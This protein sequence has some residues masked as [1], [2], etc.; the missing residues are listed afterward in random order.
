MAYSLE[1]FLDKKKSALSTKLNSLRDELA[2]K[3]AEYE[4]LSG[5]S[6]DSGGYDSDTLTRLEREISNLRTLVAKYEKTLNLVTLEAKFFKYVILLGADQYSIEDRDR[7]YQILNNRFQLSETNEDALFRKF[8]SMI[9]GENDE[10]IFVKFF[11]KDEYENYIKAREIISYLK[12][13]EQD[14][15]IEG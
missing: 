8:S 2:D 13:V 1:L 12:Q 4:T 10:F 9:S 11:T 15:S 14:D 3:E 6:S 5:G 7:L